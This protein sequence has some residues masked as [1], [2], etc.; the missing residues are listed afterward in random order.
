MSPTGFKERLQEEL[1]TGLNDVQRQAVLHAEGPLLIVAGAGS[2]KT[3]VI[4]H[5]IV[6]LSRVRDVFPYHIAAVTFTNK[7]AQEMRER[8]ENLMGPM[9]QDVF[10]RTFHSLGLFVLTR[11]AKEAG[12]K[13]NFTIYDTA[14]QNALLKQILKD[15]KIE[16]ETLTMQ[17]ASA[18]INQARDALIGPEEYSGKDGFYGNELK[19]VYKEY[20]K[21]LRANNAIDFGDLLYETVKLFHKN[22]EVLEHYR[23]R[24][25]YFMIDEYQDT[26]KAQYELGRLIAEN[27]KNI[28]VVGDDDQ[29]IYS[30]RGADVTNILN[31]EKDY[32]DCKILKLEENYRSTPLILQAASSV[33]A[34]NRNRLDKTL[35][36]SKEES[37]PLT[38]QIYNTD[39]DEARSIVGKVRG[40]R[41]QGRP[42]KEMAIFYRT[43]SQ[44]RIFE[45]IL[46]DEGLPYILVGGFRF[47]ERKEIRDIMAYLAVIANPADNI[48]LMRIINVPARGVGGVSVQKLENFAASRGMGMLAAMALAHEMPGFRSAAK[49]KLLYDLFA[50]WREMETR[51]DSP[52]DI[53]DSVL[54]NSGYLEFLNKDPSPDSLSRIDNLEQFVS[55]VTEYVENFRALPAELDESGVPLPGPPPATRPSLA[56]YLQRISLYTAESDPGEFQGEEPLFLMTLHNAKGLEFPVVFMSGMEDGLM[57]HSLSMDEGGL[58]EERRLMYVGITRAME[59][60]HLSGCRARRI[61]GSFQHRTPSRFLGEIASDVFAPGEGPDPEDSYN[62]E[63]EDDIDN[64]YSRSSYSGGGGGGRINARPRASAGVR[65]GASRSRTTSKKSAARK[66]GGKR[67]AS[68]ELIKGL[69]NARNS[70]MERNTETFAAG[71]RVSHNKFGQGKVTNVEDS[72]AGQVLV[73]D[74]EQGETRKFLAHISPLEK[75]QD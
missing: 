13:S 64:F 22:P 6:Y 72:V 68:G 25:R 10:V 62:P 55:S 65:G 47:Y 8:L 56:D 17:A 73:V 44:S 19:G 14:A 35:F 20:I 36:T 50:E 63:F 57:P 7:A 24:W 39:S 9:A 28:V 16:K 4:T 32:P 59:E 74:F 34:L 37:L 41:S 66:S 12:L 46:Q 60:L 2:G 48:S 49:L 38:Y 42:L 58:E 43:N 23:N 29:S 11:H 70:G 27:H 18:G 3:R 75:L 40:L 69:R 54:K 15:L 26:N 5:R 61:F 1:L 67:D 71:D 30:W 33:I 52:V 31:F 51:G 21:R 45:Q 53:L